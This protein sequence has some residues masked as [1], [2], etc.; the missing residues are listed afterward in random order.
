MVIASATGTAARIAH[1]VPTSPH[2][3]VSTEAAVTIFGIVVGIGNAFAQ[4]LA[5][6]RISSL[7]RDTIPLAALSLPFAVGI[8]GLLTA[9]YLVPAGGPGG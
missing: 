9:A 8:F 7:G 2:E 3:P 5:A 4:L 1:R 6:S